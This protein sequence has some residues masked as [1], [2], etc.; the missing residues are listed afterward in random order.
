[1]KARRAGCSSSYVYTEWVAERALWGDIVLAIRALRWGTQKQAPQDAFFDSRPS[2]HNWLSFADG[3]QIFRRGY[4]LVWEIMAA[5][6]TSSALAILRQVSSR[7]LRFSFSIKLI[8]ARLRPV[9]SASLSCDKPF[10][11]RTAIR[12]DTIFAASFSDSSSLITKDNQTL[13][14]IFIRNY[15]NESSRRLIC[16]FYS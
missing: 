6:S 15:S 11:I 4:F 2:P 10:S 7:G 16:A 14:Q 8:V 3:V 12:L 1:M 13:A 5:R 9:F